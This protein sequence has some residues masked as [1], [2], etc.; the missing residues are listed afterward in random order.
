MINVSALKVGNIVKVLAVNRP[1]LELKVGETLR[2][3]KVGHSGWDNM[4]YADCETN[5]GQIIEIMKNYKD[6]ELVC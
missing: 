6:F 1:Y 5:T 2:V 3:V 4:Y